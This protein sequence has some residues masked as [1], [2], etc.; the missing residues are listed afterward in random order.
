MLDGQYEQELEE[1]VSTAR[2]LREEALGVLNR[3]EEVEKQSTQD[4][5]QFVYLAGVGLMTEFIFHELERAVS[6]TMKDDL[7]GR[8]DARQRVHAE[9]SATDAAQARGSVR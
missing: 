2:D 9:G 4:R 8:G 7:R 6:H 5:E 3:L 1:V